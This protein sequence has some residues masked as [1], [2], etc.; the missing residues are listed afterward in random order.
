MQTKGPPSSMKADLGH[1]IWFTSFAV[2]SLALLLGVA[3]VTLLGT[4][5]LWVCL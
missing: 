5:E 2:A 1:Q 4:L 3:T